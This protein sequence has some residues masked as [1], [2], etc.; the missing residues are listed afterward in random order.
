MA[1]RQRLICASR[2][3][4]ERGRGY[5]FGVDWAGERAPA[6]VVRFRG[7]VH[8]YLNRCAH[9]PVEMDWKPGDFF[10]MSGLYL[11]C[12]THGALYAPDSG[13]CLGGRCDGRG[14]TPVP[15]V[16]RDGNI[17]LIESE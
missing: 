7:R 1:A 16:E 15:V 17:Y 10:D 8:A 13:H 3:V 12:A 5:C 6:F 2:E 11:I 4:A 14:L 9:V